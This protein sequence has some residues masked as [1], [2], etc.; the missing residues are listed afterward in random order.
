MNGLFRMLK[1]FLV[2]MTALLIG[3]DLSQADVLI[4][5]NTAGE[6]SIQSKIFILKDSNKQLTI[7]SVSTPPQINNLY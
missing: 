3:P 6:I 4:S 2:A 1:W 7:Q 5:V